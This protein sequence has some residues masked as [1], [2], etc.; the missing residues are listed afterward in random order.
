MTLGPSMLILSH[1]EGLQNRCATWLMV[2]G[3]VPFFF[4]LAHLLAIHLLAIP[5]AAYQ[6]FGWDA[7]FLDEFVTMDDSLTGYGLSLLGV[8]LIWAMIVV[9]LY[10]PSRWWMVYKRKHPEK[11]WLSYL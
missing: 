4:Y 9:L 10:G 2:F 6:G 1:F 8:Y 7:M 11:A 3:K 5:V